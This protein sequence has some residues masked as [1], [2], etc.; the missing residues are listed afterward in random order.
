MKKILVLT[1]MVVY[2]VL[3]GTL[4]AGTEWKEKDEFH[5]VMAQTFHP[6]EEGN[7]EPIRN[8]VGEMHEKALAW[9]KSAAPK[10]FD[11]PEIKTTL[12]DLVKGTAELKEMIESKATNEQIK[13]KLEALHDTFHK[14]VGLC[15]HDDHKSHDGKSGKHN[16]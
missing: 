4:V 16:E 1:A 5:K 12:N 15:R 8:R 3:P 7:F 14:I 9:S 6:S 10:E 2:S 13:P 11:K